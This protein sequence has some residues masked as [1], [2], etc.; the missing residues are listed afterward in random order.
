[1]VK[2][3]RIDKEIRQ[4]IRLNYAQSGSVWAAVG[5]SEHEHSGADSGGVEED[6]VLK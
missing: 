4:V 1:M 3:M 2:R 5:A 6:S